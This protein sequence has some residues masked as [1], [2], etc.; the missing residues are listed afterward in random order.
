LQWAGKT[1]ALGTFPSLEADEKCA[2]A[3]ALT[4][5]WRS[6]MRPKPTREW[7]MVELERL[8]VRVVSGRLGRKA[9][10]EGDEDIDDIKVEAEGVSGPI[11]TSNAS[12]MGGDILG[13]N[14]STNWATDAELNRLMARRNSSLGFSMLN[15]GRRGSLGSLGGLMGLD[16][17]DSN[18]LGMGIGASGFGLGSDFS[19]GP[20]QQRRSSSLGLGSLAGG[21]IGN[22][23][24]SVN[25]NQ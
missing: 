16:S 21:G 11:N 2:R 25:P 10:E 18:M 19:K 13:D 3:K 4:R 12:G 14:N 5:A 17:A 6:T 1:I 15:E 20:D 8:G 24:L 7:V 22:I 9:G 23:G